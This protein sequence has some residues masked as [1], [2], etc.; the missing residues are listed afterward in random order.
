MAE[1]VVSLQRTTEESIKKS[2]EEWFKNTSEEESSLN[3][4]G[5]KNTNEEERNHTYSQG[6]RSFASV[7]NNMVKPEH[8]P[9]VLS[10]TSAKLTSLEMSQN[11][12]ATLLQ[13]ELV[14]RSSKREAVET[15]TT[16]MVHEANSN[17]ARSLL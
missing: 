10:F 8:T 7:D 6:V 2:L 16:I 1:L 15:V 5:F 11:L 12:W 14:G 9:G 4:E 3:K 17:T 13:I